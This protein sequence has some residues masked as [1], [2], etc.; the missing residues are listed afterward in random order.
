[1][2][3]DQF[4][5]LANKPKTT[6]KKLTWQHWA[7]QCYLN[8]LNIETQVTESRTEGLLTQTGKGAQG[9]WIVD[10]NGERLGVQMGWL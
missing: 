9:G 7:K 8:R 6:N 4:Q 2:Y 10:R 3:P 1:M 5:W